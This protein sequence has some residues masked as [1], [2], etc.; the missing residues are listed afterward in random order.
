[1]PNWTQDQE[2][3]L[4]LNIIGLTNPKPPNWQDV[5]SAMGNGFSKEAC[6][7]HFQKIKRETKS[8]KSSSAPTTPSKN[9]TPK[10]PTSKSTKRK[11][12][13]FSQ[14]FDNVDDDATGPAD[15]YENRNPFKKMK[16]EVDTKDMA[17]Q[18]KTEHADTPVVDLEDDRF[19][20]LI[21]T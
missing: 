10:T 9:G 7:Q 20:V 1:M 6:R 18:F 17:L 13:A 5:A 3:K 15:V 2:F 16:A 8:S 12:G 14:D 21:Q 19:I 11:A 4:L